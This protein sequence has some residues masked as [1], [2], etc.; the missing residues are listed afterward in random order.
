M[1]EPLIRRF[2]DLIIPGFGQSDSKFGQLK[3]VHQFCSATA[4]GDAI[5]NGLILIRDMLI[6]LG[7]RSEIFV[8]S[9][10]SRFRRFSEYQSSP[11]NTLLVHHSM[12]LDNIDRIVRLPD[13]KILI[14][15]NI[16]PPELLIDNHHFHK[17]AII[18]KRQLKT[19]C[20]N[21]NGAIADS[22]YNAQDLISLNYQ[23]IKIIPLL[24]NL[25]SISSQPFDKP[26]ANQKGAIFT[27]IFVG[28]MI[29]SKGQ[30]DLVLA[31]DRFRKKFSNLS[32]LI[33]IGRIDCNSYFQE[34]QNT[35]RLLGLQ[36]FVHIT[37]QI[38]DDELYGWYRVSDLYLSLSQHEGFGVPLVESMIFDVPVL[39]FAAGAVSWVVGNQKQLINNKDPEVVSDAMLKLIQDNSILKT[40]LAEQSTNCERFKFSKIKKQFA[41]SLIE[42]GVKF[43]L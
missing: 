43:P 29:R 37:G 42:F 38:S 6:E 5:T 33:L 4:Y 22:P 20:A 9:P 28:R 1:L 14:Y 7:F 10:D 30:V 34:V 17:Y 36:G 3:S 26:L 40:I 21:V 35:I 15:H 31:F 39:A 19:Y 12:G 24:F 27:V 8:D 16:T 13:L 11:E 32:R 18:G 2:K 23:K 41:D 25:D